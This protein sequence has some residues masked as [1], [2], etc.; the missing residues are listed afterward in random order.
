MFRRVLSVGVLNKNLMI[1]NYDCSLNQSQCV[2]SK[3]VPRAF[4]TN[5]QNDKQQEFAIKV[6]AAKETIEI[7]DGSNAKDVYEYPFVWLRDNCQCPECFHQT[8]LSRTLNWENFDLSVSPKNVQINELKKTL[9][10]TWSD[11][12]HQSE[13][14]FQWLKERN[15]TQNNREKYLKKF[16]RPAK[17]LFGKKDFDKIVKSFDFQKII[18]NDDGELLTKM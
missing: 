2:I 10:V 15:F 9:E 5:I 6:N 17:N 1:R 13:Y 4:T 16:Y 14:S 3:I 7:I 18:D 12:D 11:K 8:S